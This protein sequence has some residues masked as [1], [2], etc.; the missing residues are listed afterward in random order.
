M[1]QT[2]KTAPV[3]KESWSIIQEVV[4]VV[5]VVTVQFF[6]VYTTIGYGNCQWIT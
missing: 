2:F 4:V 1:Q 3:Q 6:Q 5:V